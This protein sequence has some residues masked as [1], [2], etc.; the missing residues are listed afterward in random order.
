MAGE[1]KPAVAN[2]PEAEISHK[3]EKVIENGDKMGWNYFENCLDLNIISFAVFIFKLKTFS[4]YIY[5]SQN[6][7]A[8][9][10]VSWFLAD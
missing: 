8:L 4:N 1:L 2:Q 6:S 10:N 7:I 9:L 5:I 3:T